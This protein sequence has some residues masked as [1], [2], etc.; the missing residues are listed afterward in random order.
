MDCLTA[1]YIYSPRDFLTHHCIEVDRQGVVHALRPLQVDDQ[2]IRYE[3]IICPGFINA[4]CHLELSALRGKV[5]TGLGMT[6]FIQQVITQRNALDKAQIHQAIFDSIRELYFTGTVAVGDICNTAESVSFKQDFS[7]LYTRSFI[8]LLGV[9]G[10]KAETILKEG[11]S[12]A[13]SFEELPHS[14]T[15]H[16]PYS[17]SSQLRDLVYQSGSELYSLH[18]L[19]SEAERMLFEQGGGPFLAF[20]ESM[21]L[22]LPST[23]EENPAAYLMKGMARTQPVLMVHMTEVKEAELEDLLREFPLAYLCICPRSNQY[24]HKRLPNIPMLM[25]HTDR[26]CIG[27][28]SL[29]SNHDLRMLEE[30]K[31]IQTHFPRIDLLTQ[32]NWLCT[33]GADALQVSH[34]FGKF[35]EGE[36]CGVNLIEHIEK[37]TLKLTPNS[38]VRKLF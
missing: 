29:A 9:I 23:A 11:K 26:I 10:E 12:L 25:Q 7:P 1:D 4:H 38:T 3:G 15:L 2:P 6:G 17:V 14:L 37:N 5:P 33:K 8:E 36:K 34:K 19:E 24:L 28:D 13:E 32:L 20:Y 21:G 27:T 30:L 22:P 31:C 35:V 16:A 18:L